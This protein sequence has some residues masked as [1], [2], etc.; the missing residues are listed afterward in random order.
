MTGCLTDIMR[1]KRIDFYTL[2][3]KNKKLHPT[4]R[5]MATKFRAQLV[6]LMRVERAD[7]IE[8][9]KKRTMAALAAET[10]MYDQT[11]DD[12]KVIIMRLKDRNIDE[13][14]ARTDGTASHWDT[15]L[16][17]Q[18]KERHKRITEYNA[19]V[20]QQNVSL[21]HLN[22]GISTIDSL[23]RR[24]AIT[25]TS[26]DIEASE[27]FKDIGDEFEISPITPLASAPGPDEVAYMQQEQSVIM[28][29]V[30]PTGADKGADDAFKTQ[31][32]QRM[33]VYDDRP[34]SQKAPVS[35]GFVERESSS[36]SG[37]P[38]KMM[39]SEF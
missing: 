30:V 34:R 24:F 4:V 13:V 5:T 36:S 15:I 9:D 10:Q 28:M 35:S 32:L 7:E 12:E 29:Q 38:S 17:P 18:L 23:L 3:M 25:N 26:G 37:R 31:L 19:M 11:I 27:L 1:K 14:I 6:R 39:E 20:A 21:S 8:V 22:V 33:G 16:I 2:V